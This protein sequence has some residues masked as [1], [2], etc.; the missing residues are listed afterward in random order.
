MTVFTY[1]KEKYNYPL[2]YGGSVSV[3]TIEQLK[4]I[5]YLDGVLLG[6]ASLRVEDVSEFIKKL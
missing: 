5:P 1:L 2:L 3:A 4:D 6:K